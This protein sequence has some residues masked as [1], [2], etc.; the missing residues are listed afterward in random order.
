MGGLL[1]WLQS[2]V[3]LNHF[4]VW[5]YVWKYTPAP[6]IIQGAIVTVILSVISQLL[7][8]LIGLMLYFLRRG[9]IRVLR[10]IADAYIWF[11]RGT[12]LAVQILA[13]YTLFPY[14]HL[15]RPLRAIDPFS[16]IGFTHGPGPI[17]LDSFLAA[18]L[19]LSLNEGAYMAEIVRAGIDAIDVGQL[20]A[21]KSL[22]MTYSLAMRR[23]VLPQAFRIIIPPLGNEFNNMLKNTALAAFIALN[24]L[25]ETGRLIGDANFASLELLVVAS[26]WY[27]LL[28]TIWGFF[29]GIIERKLNASNLDPG[30]PRPQWWQRAF[31]FGQGN[32][33]VATAVPAEH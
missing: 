28:T 12:P 26:L 30:A 27:L 9:R 29:Q 11:F 14:L 7:G 1:E 31:G 19:A 3:T 21:A 17:F 10:I 25:L 23:I 22:G 15:S 32:A 2:V 24:E 6:S 5:T 4:F 20:E 13:F 16:A 8:T 33:G 18:I